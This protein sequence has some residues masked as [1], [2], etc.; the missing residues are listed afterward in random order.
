LVAGAHAG[1]VRRCTIRGAGELA[2]RC[3]VLSPAWRVVHLV[4]S[5]N[6][7]ESFIQRKIG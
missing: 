6:V 5:R 4:R 1:G 3:W 7:D 2:I